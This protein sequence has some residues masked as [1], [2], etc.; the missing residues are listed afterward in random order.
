MTLDELAH[1]D[2]ATFPDTPLLVAICGHIFDVSAAP[3]MYTPPS[4]YARLIGR[5]AGYA[6]GVFDVDAIDTQD[7]T[8]LST[9]TPEEWASALAWRQRLGTKY[10]FVGRVLSTAYQWPPFATTEEIATCISAHGTTL[11]RA[12]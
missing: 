12:K 4:D 10:R 3:H 1:F 5:E 9:L 8:N 2:G 7:G 6:F 11:V